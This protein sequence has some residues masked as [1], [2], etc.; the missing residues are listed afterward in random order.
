MRTSFRIFRISGIDINIHISL[1]ILL[2]LLVY[3]FYISPPPY[4]FADFGEM[5]R[6]LLSFFA[7][8][9]LFVAILI[10]EF[11]H[12]IF[13]RKFGVKVRAI[14]LFI[15]GGV[16]MMESMPKKPREEFIV[17]IAG[18]AASLLIALISF[19]LSFIPL[20]E[21]SAF[22]TLFTYFNVIL[23]AFNLIPA[24]PMDGGRV[25]RSFLAD[26]KSYAEATRIAAE[27]GR[28]LAVFMAIFGI[29]YNPWLILIAL[30]IYIGASE[31]ERIVLLENVLGKVKVK[32]IMT[33]NVV[34]LTPEMRVSEVMTLLLKSKH[35]GYP[36]I[37][38]DKLVGIVTLHDI[39]NA[40][41]NTRVGEVMTKE[42]IT[43]EPNRS[44][45]E[46]FKIMSER[47][48]GRLPVTENGK[49]VGIVSRSDLMRVKEILEALEVMGWKRS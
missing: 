45:F 47:K 9:A 12:S 32:D 44:A 43:V 23:A 25:L 39:I 34:S 1:V 5:K 24:F 46:A 11:A 3:A 26:R 41:P 40:D 21:L 13:A 33:E 31:E 6:I 38:D 10:H 30:F 7:A 8:I 20:R 27:I 14:M 17:S 18:P 15:F 28:A 4:G 49:I 35:L 16:S 22:F 36:V 2:A 29:F 48:I 42:V 19:I 37:D